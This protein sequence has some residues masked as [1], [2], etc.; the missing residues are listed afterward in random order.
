ML[1]SMTL[2]LLNGGD[3]GAVAQVAGD[4]LQVLQVFAHQLGAAV[5]HVPVGGAV[6]AVAAHG[7]LLVVLVGDVEHV[8]LGG[9]GG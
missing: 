2:P 9:H 6:E 8:G 5:A 3:G 7:V 1:V 4:H